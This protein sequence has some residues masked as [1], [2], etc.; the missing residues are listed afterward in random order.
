MSGNDILGLPRDIALMLFEFSLVVVTVPLVLYFLDRRKWARGRQHMGSILA[1]RVMELFGLYKTFDVGIAAMAQSE[2]FG[3]FWE[4]HRSQ[5][6]EL[7][8]NIADSR[9]R[10][11][12]E[13][14]LLSQ[15]LDSASAIA[16]SEFWDALYRLSLDMNR[17]VAAGP[18]EEFF[19]RP[20]YE[21]EVIE[22]DYNK[23]KEKF[24]VAV[25]ALGLKLQDDYVAG[26]ETLTVAGQTIRES[27]ADTARNIH[28]T[29]IQ[30]ARTGKAPKD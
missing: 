2:N 5:R 17:V 29:C 13:L 14:Q 8:R 28:A 21:R 3:N 18:M 25:E 15:A 27:P 12:Q 11:V 24:R 9:Q 16:I 19:G 26:F 20:V 1:R 30:G 22:R 10:A 4:H 7:F 6:E 23:V